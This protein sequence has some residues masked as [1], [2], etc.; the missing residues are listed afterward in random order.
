MSPGL[1][2][3]LLVPIATEYSL[4]PWSPRVGECGGQAKHPGAAAEQP[5]I[6]PQGPCYRLCSTYCLHIL[7][8]TGAAGSWRHRVLPELNA[9]MAWSPPELG[10]R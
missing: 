2:C 10:R 4:Q 5:A 3:R 6:L 8:Q 9:K 1:Y 7:A